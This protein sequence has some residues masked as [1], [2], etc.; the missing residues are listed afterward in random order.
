L[1]GHRFANP[2]GEGVQSCLG[3]DPGSLLVVAKAAARRR[4]WWRY[5]ALWPS[6]AALA[7]ARGASSD[8]VQHA[9]KQHHRAGS[10]TPGVRCSRRKASCTT[11][12][13]SK[14][15]PGSGRQALPVGRARRTT[16]APA[17]VPA[18]P[19]SLH[20]AGAAVL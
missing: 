7:R 9:D 18:S 15:L 16:P 2:S 4:A 19:A 5:Q 13:A 11:S 20:A 8:G 14:T 1:A 12:S 10:S 6:S 3:Q 17:C